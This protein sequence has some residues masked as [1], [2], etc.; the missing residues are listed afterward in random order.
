MNRDPE[1]N[2]QGGYKKQ[3]EKVLQILVG[4]I[5]VDLRLIRLIEVMLIQVSEKRSKILGISQGQS[6]VL[7]KLPASSLLPPRTPSQAIP[8]IDLYLSADKSSERSLLRVLEPS[9]TPT[10]KG[11]TSLEPRRADTRT[12]T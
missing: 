4:G 6:P 2:H 7:Q 9:P 3:S 5:V 12:N 8:A 11:K 1:N 10:P